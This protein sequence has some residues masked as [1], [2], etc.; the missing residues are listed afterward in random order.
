MK[1]YIIKIELK[2]SNPLIWRKVIIPAGATFNRLHDIIQGVTNF[3]SGYPCISTL[4]LFEFDLKEENIRVT[5]DE[6]A[7]QEHQQYKKNKKMYEERLKTIPPE[8]AKFEKAHQKRLKTAVRKPVS[9]KIDDY[10]EKYKVIEYDY[11]FSDGW[12]F[13]ITLED[14]VDDY[15]FGFPTLLDGAETA[16]PE[17]VGGLP[18]FY[19]F[20]KVHMDEK[21]PEHK[22]VVSWAKEQYFREYDPDQT[23]RYLKCLNYKKTEWDKINHER[24]K[25]IDDKY[26]KE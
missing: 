22:N 14:I 7:Y 13:I 9:L 18:G 16:P 5:N 17:D 3:K 24:Y 19:E 25:I 12:Q 15:Y 20:L 6:Q 2:N 4:H 23:N 26:R 8:L 21:H 10:I 1:S 11:D